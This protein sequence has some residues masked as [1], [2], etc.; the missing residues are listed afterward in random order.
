MKILYLHQYFNTPAMSGGTRSFEMARRLVEWGHE[1]H[2]I[3]S[4]RAG[5]LSPGQKWHKTEEA[6]IHVYWTSI[7]YS[8]KL[9]YSQRIKAFF[10]FSWRAARKAVEIGGDIVFA[11]S[12]PLTIAL[13][14]VYASKRLKIPMV[15]EVRDLWPEVPIALG[16]L[17]NPLTKYSARWLE[18]FAYKN[19][20]R[21]IA[22]APGMKEHIVG[23][24]YPA[25]KITVIPNGCDMELFDVRKTAREAVRNKYDWLRDRP[26]VV[27]AG[28]LGMVNG[29][30]FLVE[31]A[32]ATNCIS[33]DIRFVVIGSGREEDIIRKYAEDKKVLDKNF[34]MLGRIPKAEL[35]NWLSAATVCAILYNGPEI[36]WRDS[37]PN[38]FFDCIAAKKPF[39]SNI[40]GWSQATGEKAG[41]GLILDM[42]NIQEAAKQ[43]YDSLGDTKWLENASQA[44]KGLAKEF[45]RE[46]LAKNLEAVLLEACTQKSTTWR[47]R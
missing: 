21:I 27:Y 20:S 32:E 37:V 30:G 13:P 23:K 47:T 34:F 18:Q 14:G 29:V 7:P 19:S 36:V 24:G 4:E 25:E 40:R 6:G 12:T 10:S 43:L 33:P 17:K 16:A 45:D 35:P 5:L 15:F 3:T 22:L 11:T 44:A 26:L 9:S 41:A 39:I 46:K 28:T 31:L 2:M 42:N 8:N 1:V 38:K